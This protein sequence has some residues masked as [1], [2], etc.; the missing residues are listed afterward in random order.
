MRTAAH[1]L[2]RNVV[3]SHLNLQRFPA[4]YDCFMLHPLADHRCREWLA[5]GNLLTW[6][7]TRYGCTR[8]TTLE[9][10]GPQT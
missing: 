9:K 2:A 6:K 3:T 1:N 4:I 5:N 8:S 7:N 10:L